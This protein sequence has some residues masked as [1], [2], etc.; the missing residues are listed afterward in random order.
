MGGVRRVLSIEDLLWAP[1]LVVLDPAWVGVSRI[2]PWTGGG[3]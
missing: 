1:W 3:V 2:E